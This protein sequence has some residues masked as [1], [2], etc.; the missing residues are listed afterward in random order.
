MNIDKSMINGWLNVFKAQGYTSSHIVRTLKKKFNIKKIG[1]YGTLDPLASGVLPLAM[2]EA[3]KTIKFITCNQKAYSFFINWGKETNTSDE[4]GKVI[5]ESSKRPNMS[6]IK[7][8]IKKYFTGNILQKPPI[9]SAVKVNGKRA[10][11]LARKNLNFEIKSKKIN[12][13]KFE[14]LKI[15]NKNKAQ[16]TVSCG[17]GTYVRSLARDLAKELGTFG[18][19]SNI[20]RL[21]NSYF[22]VSNSINYDEIMKLN[23]LNFYNNL[24]PI[25]YVLKNIEE[26]KLEKK[27]SDMLKNGKIVFVSK[28][29]KNKERDRYFLIKYNSELVS[30]ANLKKGYII[31]RR[32]FNN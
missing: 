10:Y 11:E 16:F 12:I 9:Y 31:P 24:L 28:Y 30:I 6:E 18:Y 32:N 25:D 2:G 20:V 3:T 8:V 22:S 17:P 15:I 21:K 27:Y 23:K 14:L 4:E 1:H 7:L 19:A 26:I 5:N 29:N 13:K